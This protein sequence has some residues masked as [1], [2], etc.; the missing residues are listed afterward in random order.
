M[1]TL[2]LP[3]LESIAVTPNETQ[4]PSRAVRS[5]RYLLGRGMS[6]TRF[7]KRTFSLYSF[8]TGL[9]KVLAHSADLYHMRKRPRIERSFRERIMLAVTQVNDCRYCSYVHARMALQAGLSEQE[10]SELLEGDLEHSPPDQ[11]VALAFAQH[12]AEQAGRP[13]QLTLERLQDSYG[14]ESTNEIM[15]SIRVIY[16]A[17]LLGNTFDKLL[18]RFKPATLR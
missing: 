14:P 8:W 7:E 17:N 4:V 10:I 9:G 5:M 12:Y 16:F 15:A 2:T 13:D 6:K 11:L 18:H 1:R 3:N